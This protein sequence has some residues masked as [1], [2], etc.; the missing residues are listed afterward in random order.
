MLKS[1][2]C[3]DSMQNT[4]I[5]QIYAYIHHRGPV[6]RAELIEK[7]HLNRGKVT[8]SLKYLLDHQ[9]IYITGHADSGGGRPAAL[10]QLHPASGYVIGVQI[11]RY[12]TNIGLFNV[13]FEKLAQD[14]VIMTTEHTPAVT[15]Q[16][17]VQSIK[18]IL[19]DRGIDQRDVLGVGAGAIGPLD[20][21]KGMILQPETFIAS[22]WEYV[23]VQ[24]TLEK[25]LQVPVLVENGANVGALGEYHAHQYYPNVLNVTSGWAWGCGVIQNGSIMHVRSGD[26]SRYGHMTV[27]LHGKRCSCGKHGCAVAYTSLYN[28]LDCIKEEM[29]DYYNQHIGKRRVVQIDELIPFLRNGGENL[30]QIIYSTAP[31]LGAGVANLAT[32]FHA[33]L[34]VLNGPL[35]NY[36]PGFFE[37]VQRQV[38]NHMDIK[39]RT[40]ISKGTY[41][42]DSGMM[43]AALFMFQHW[44]TETNPR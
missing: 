27:N 28:I 26:V 21:K 2:L 43:G 8:R 41:A 37:E 3:D 29:P 5:K 6:S 16:S 7:L 44:L 36:Y 19:H 4:F 31:Y 40:T 33:D 17:V 1:F 30:K 20:R 24:E 10:Y 39:Q 35:I 11:T 22:G 12:Q 42:G 15:L 13:L 9:F 38:Q 25:E 32:A 23:P 18:K 14:T 34:I